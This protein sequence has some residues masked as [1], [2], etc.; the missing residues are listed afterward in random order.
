VWPLARLYS[1]EL[2]CGGSQVI[3]CSCTTVVVSCVHVLSFHS[4]SLVAMAMQQALQPAPAFKYTLEQR[5]FL[6]MR[7]YQ[8]S[9]NL[10]TV[11]EEFDVCY[12]NVPF[13]SH[14]ML[15][16]MHHK[17]QRTGSIADA[18]H[19]GRPHTRRCEGNL[20]AVAQAVVED[21]HCS[22]RRGALE[23]GITRRTYQRIFNDLNIHVYRPWLVQQLSEDDF[24]RRL[25]FAEW[26]LSCSANNP[27]FYR[28]LVW[29]DGASFKLNGIIAIIACIGQQTTRTL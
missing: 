28:S 13:P 20:N 1:A 17:F 14:Q 24:D 4:G 11:C 25:E 7:Y 5:T 15:R 3:G 2:R 16:N 19:S 21:P 6:L 8:L 10:S 12:P 22:T 18:P 9:A 29:S 27:A 26:Y 23:L